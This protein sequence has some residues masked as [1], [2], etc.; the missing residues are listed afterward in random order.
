MVAVERGH[1]IKHLILPKPENR[2]PASLS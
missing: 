1:L 2:T